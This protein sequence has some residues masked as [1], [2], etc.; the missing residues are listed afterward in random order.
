MRKPKFKSITENLKTVSN[1]PSDFEIVASTERSKAN[2]RLVKQF[3][4]E[5]C[6]YDATESDFS[7]WSIDKSTIVHAY[8]QMEL[9]TVSKNLN[10]LENN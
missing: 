9:H 10:R 6:I 8:R 4:A 1:I 2:E 7:L 5:T 3:F